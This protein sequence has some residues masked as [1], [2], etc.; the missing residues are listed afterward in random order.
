M[1]VGNFIENIKN[2][3]YEDQKFY[4]IMEY[5]QVKIIQGGINPKKNNYTEKDHII[6]GI[7]PSIP[8]EIKL[9]K[10]IEPKYNYQMK[11][12]FEISNLKNSFEIGSIAMVKTGEI[13]SSSTEFF[14]VTN[15]ILELEGRYSVFGKIVQGKQVLEKIDTEDIIFEIKIIN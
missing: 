14:F 10:K 2:N 5:S 11:D 4:K 15:E 8:L 7:P 1:T 6:R 3:I 9:N 12:P 13:N